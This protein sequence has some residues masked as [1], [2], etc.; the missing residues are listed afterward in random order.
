MLLSKLGSVDKNGKYL[1]P[2]ELKREHTLSAKEFAYLFTSLRCM[3]KLTFKFIFDF[4][5]CCQK[6]YMKEK[7]TGTFSF[8]FNF[9]VFWVFTTSALRHECRF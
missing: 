4:Y 5:P 9:P 8:L 3:F 2:E 7:H 6:R 1:Q